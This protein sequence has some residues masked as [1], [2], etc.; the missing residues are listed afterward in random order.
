LPSQLDHPVKKTGAA[1]KHGVRGNGVE[2]SGFRVARSRSGLGLFALAP[3]RK[4]AFIIEYWGKR[5]SSEEADE[6]RTRYLF[7]L[8]D[9]WTLDGSDRRNT[10]RY[11]NHSCKP[12]AVAYAEKGS[13]R[14][15]AKKNIQPGDEITYNY[16]R[17]YF[18]VFLRTRG[19]KCASCTAEPKRRDTSRS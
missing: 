15:Y 9:R 16:G 2:P 8:N 12:N 14:I 3:I 19:C 4:G 13:I 7:E 1:Q 17:R 6:L 5:V 10:A 11:I 18:E